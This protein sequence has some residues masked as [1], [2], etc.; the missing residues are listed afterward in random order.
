[1]K[2]KILVTTRKQKIEG[3]NRF[4]IHEDYITALEDSIP[5]MSFTMEEA[6]IEQIIT[7][8]DGLL[9]TGGDDIDPS[10]YNQENRSSKNI[11][12]TIDETDLLLIQ[13]F[14]KANKPILGICRG[15]QMLNVA[16]GGSL[17]QDIPSEIETTIEHAPTDKINTFVTSLNHPIKVI[18]NT[19]LYKL[20]QGNTE[21]NSYHHQAIDELAPSLTVSAIAPDGIVEAVEYSSNVLAVQWHPE[22]MIEDSKQKAIFTWFITRCLE[23]KNNS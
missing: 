2:P 7:E 3:K 13:A 16:L 8:F 9:V 4:Y 6:E 17:I 19:M 12:T 11:D 23:T 21:V 20:L 10:Y 18:P 22:R 14:I 1:M 15:L 5:L